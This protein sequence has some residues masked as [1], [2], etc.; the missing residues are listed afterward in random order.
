[1]I[2]IVGLGNPGKNYEKTVHN[3]GFMAVDYFAKKNN[4]TFSKST[5]LS[6]PSVK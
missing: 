2:A 6:P 4:L 1:M 3:M 5:E